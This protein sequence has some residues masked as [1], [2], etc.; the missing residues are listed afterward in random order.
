M[1]ETLAVPN[2]RK[3]VPDTARGSPRCPGVPARPPEPS[4]PAIIAPVIRTLWKM[5]LL[6]A[7]AAIALAAV[8]AGAGALSP[9]VDGMRI[10]VYDTRTRFVVDLDRSATFSVFTLSDPYR[11]VVDL[12]E[13]TWSSPLKRVSGGLIAQLRFG[14]LKPGVSRIVLD[15]GGPVRVL[16]SFL[17][18]PS[19]ALR[20]HRLVIDLVPTDRKTFMREIRARLATARTA[21]PRAAPVP[22][23]KPRDGKKLVVIDPGHGGVDPGAIS[24]SGRY[25]KHVVLAHARELRRQLLATGNYRIVMTRNRDVF[26]RLRK[27]TEKAR[28]A[29]ADLFISLHADSI[30]RPSV[31]G[32][33]VYTLSERASDR[34][35]AALAARENKSDIIAGLDLDARSSEVADILIDLSQRDTKNQSAQFAGI[36]IHEMAKVRRMLRNTHRFAGFA[37]LKAPDVPAVLVELG[38][39]SNRADERLLL[40]T[41]ARLRVVSAI[42]RAIDRYFGSR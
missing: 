10:G 35:A 37:V 25:E 17:L 9:N 29:G 27:R 13:V 2:G 14:L 32:A 4:R 5:A 24:R 6:P 34:E 11:V 42:V 40:D 3:D 33:S 15:V 22:R 36:L 16:K 20:H 39:L 30:A 1:A 38:Y 19:D 21:P 7:L 8:P 31:R 26:M 18:A 28:A 12:P 41:K 23:P